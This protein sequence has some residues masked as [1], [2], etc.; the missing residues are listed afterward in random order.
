MEE[1]SEKEEFIDL[2]HVG[3][4]QDIYKVRKIML[5]V[6]FAKVFR[7]TESAGAV[8]GCAGLVKVTA[9]EEVL[10]ILST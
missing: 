4:H 8:F 2:K 9:L 1:A 6:A 5:C 3:Q 7:C 10:A